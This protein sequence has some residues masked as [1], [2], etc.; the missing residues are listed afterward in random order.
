MSV[1]YT[2]SSRLYEEAYRQLAVTH[3][4]AFVDFVSEEEAGGFRPSLLSLL[5]QRVADVRLFLVDDIVFTESVN[6]QLMAKLSQ[7]GFIPSLRLG[8][9]LKR[10]YTLQR[11]QRL[12]PLRPVILATQSQLDDGELPLNLWSW[13]WRSGSLDWRYPLSVDGNVFVAS[14]IDQ[15]IRDVDFEAP[16]TLEDAL[17]VHVSKFMG[18]WGV[19][20]EKSRLVNIPMNRVQTLIPNLHGEVHQDELLQMWLKGFRLDTES[21][22][23]Y[24]NVSAHEEPPLLFTAGPR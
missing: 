19:C 17:Q 16:N 6:I 21:L 1:I 13:T 12:P 24:R 2:A 20:Y 23:G 7:V 11:S 14:E 18:R 4:N 15:M 9:N 10:S 8:R 22:H 5:N 3:R